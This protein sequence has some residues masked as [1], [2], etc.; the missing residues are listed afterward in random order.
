MY[1]S[2]TNNYVTKYHKGDRLNFLEKVEIS[3]N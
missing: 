1:L 2:A 3:D